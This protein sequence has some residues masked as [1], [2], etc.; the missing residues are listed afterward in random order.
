[1]AANNVTSPI[2][3]QAELPSGPLAQTVATGFTVL[4]LATAIAAIFWATANMRPVPPGYQT[5]VL[6]FG[7]VVRVQ[8]ACPAR[9]VPGP[10]WPGLGSLAPPSR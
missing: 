1:M 6:R 5:V 10:A 7:A 3:M 4:R 8:Q 9:G 2:H